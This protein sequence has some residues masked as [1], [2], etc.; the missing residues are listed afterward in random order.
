[1]TEPGSRVVWERVN[2]RLWR[3]QDGHWEARYGPFGGALGWRVTQ[4]GAVVSEH[5][6]RVEAIRMTGV[7]FTYAE[8]IVYTR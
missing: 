3:S 8:V 7:D 4:D 1:M 5:L 2:I 6:D